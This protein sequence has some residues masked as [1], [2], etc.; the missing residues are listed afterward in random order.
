MNLL[1]F[2]GKLSLRS[3]REKG[4]P[5]SECSGLAS[6]RIVRKGYFYRSSDSKRVPRFFCQ[7][8]RR[9]F[10]S[11][12]FSPCFLQKKR[13]V[14]H[15]VAALLDSCGS[16]R[17]T[18]RL[19]KLD[20]K[21]VARKLLFMAGRARIHQKIFQASLEHQIEAVQFDE[22]ESSE[23]T[24]CKPLSIALAVCAKSRKILAYRVCSMPAHGQLS[25]KARKK[26]GFRADRRRAAA[27]SLFSEIAPLLHPNITLTTD[28]KP[29]YSSWIRQSLGHIKHK[30]TKG[31]RGCSTGQGELKKIGF[32]PLF[33][34]NHT[35]AMLR[36]NINR[37]VR[38]TWCTTKRQDRLSDHIA[39]YVHYHNTVLTRS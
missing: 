20:L 12:S 2:R 34:L 3:R 21:T 5:F 9:S 10:S 25:E 23:A 31:R 39:L 19:L 28:E 4:C 8:C 35:A 38:R 14:N 16:Q 30:T 1:T 33:A 13:G 15:A 11:A 29:Q 17:R 26:Y 37:L 36:A 7:N 24:K 6:Q 22:M 32:D 27:L 18:A